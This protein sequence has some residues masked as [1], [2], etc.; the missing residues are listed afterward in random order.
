MNTNIKIFLL[1]LTTIALVACNMNTPEY[2]MSDL[3][4]YWLENSDSEEHYVHFT[5]EQ[6]DEVGYLFAREWNADEDKH[7]EDLYVYVKDVNGNDS[8]I[9]GNGWFQYKLEI[10]G[11]LTEIHFM[12][13]G[14]AEIPKNYIVKTLTEDKLEYY[15]EGYEKLVYSFSKVELTHD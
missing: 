9:H 13:N 2:R 11:D 10:S 6:A 15:E 1:S 8:L 4:G 3:K 14:G 5:D 12:D 7:E